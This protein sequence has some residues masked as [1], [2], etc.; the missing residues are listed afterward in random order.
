M[1]AGVAVSRWHRHGE[2]ATRRARAHGEG[3]ARRSGAR[4]P[5]PE[6]A[7]CRACRVVRYWR[8]PEPAVGLEGAPGVRSDRGKPAVPPRSRSAAT[9]CAAVRAGSRPRGRSGRI[10]SAPRHG[11]RSRSRRRCWP[12]SITGTGVI[13]A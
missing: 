11:A 9:R 12:G 1:S 7:F 8:L 3:T 5:R 6:R 4:L 13:G 2:G 10:T